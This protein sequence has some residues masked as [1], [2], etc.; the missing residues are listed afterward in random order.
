MSENPLTAADSTPPAA[1]TFK[2]EHDQSS[3]LFDL[4]YLIGG[5]MTLYGL[6]LVVV[7]FTDSTTQLN[8]ASGIRINLWMGILMVA[9]GVFFLAWAR[10]RPLR[11][12]GPSEAAEAEAAAGGAPAA[13]PVADA[14]EPR[15]SDDM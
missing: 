14:A 12:E 5:I 1:S 13:P 3:R 11:V 9:V 4:R 8:K 2:D 6:I 15:R 10:L 7:G